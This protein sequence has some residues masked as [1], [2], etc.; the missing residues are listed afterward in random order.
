MARM[1]RIVTL[2]CVAIASSLAEVVAVDSS[3]KPIEL[4]RPIDIDNDVAPSRQKVQASSSVCQDSDDGCAEW[5]EAGECTRNPQYMRIT[6]Q[7]SCNSCGEESARKLLQTAGNLIAAAHTDG[8]ENLKAAII[9]LET[10]LSLAP[11]HQQAATLLAN[12][13]FEGLGDIEGALPDFQRLWAQCLSIE[14]TDPADLVRRGVCSANVGQYAAEAGNATWAL[15]ALETSLS[16]LRSDAPSNVPALMGM[17]YAATGRSQDALRLLGKGIEAPLA[18]TVVSQLDVILPPTP[19]EAALVD[20]DGFPHADA[21]LAFDGVVPEQLLKL[22]ATALG[23]DGDWLPPGRPIGTYVSYMYRFD[24]TPRNLLEQM[25]RRFI[26]LL[27]AAS[28]QGLVACEYWAH[29]TTAIPLKQAPGQ[30]K[31]AKPPFPLAFRGH[32]FHFDDRDGESAEGESAEDEESGSLL[33]SLALYLHNNGGPNLVANQTKLSSSQADA[34]WLVAPK[35]G[36]LLR[37][38]SS[39]EQAVLPKFSPAG[40]PPP[41]SR[42]RER[43]TV[44]FGFWERRPCKRPTQLP[45]DGSIPCQERV[46][47][48]ARREGIPLAAVSHSGGKPW[49]WELPGEPLAVMP[50]DELNQLMGSE[51]VEAPYRGATILKVDPFRPV[52]E[53]VQGGDA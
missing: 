26:G 31:K 35:R 23:R 16:I 12:A 14:R 27:P 41:A 46:G 2:C 40:E 47:G 28:R 45:Y 9:L 42:G 36:R 30:S 32:G 29:A 20:S 52:W 15:E 22:L 13:R 19:T 18:A 39:L 48:I 53:Q 34:G 43:V 11:D 1:T 25:A 49:W 10:V 6:C 17:L 5:A 4:D 7:R 21:V 33:F 24:E 8:V 3:G 44:N 51:I 38:N 37:I 50:E